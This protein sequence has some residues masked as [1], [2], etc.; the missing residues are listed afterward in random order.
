MC[1]KCGK[2]RKVNRLDMCENCYRA[3]RCVYGFEYWNKK[4]EIISNNPD[5]ISPDLTQFEKMSMAAKIL[6][7]RK[8]EDRGPNC[9]FCGNPFVKG[10]IHRIGGLWGCKNCYHQIRKDTM[11]ESS[12][13]A[14]LEMKTNKLS[15]TF[16]INKIRAGWE[17]LLIFVLDKNLDWLFQGQRVIIVTEKELGINTKSPGRIEP[18]RHYAMIDQ[19]DDVILQVDESNHDASCGNWFHTEY[20]YYSAEHES[21]NKYLYN[22][23]QYQFRINTRKWNININGPNGAQTLTYSHIEFLATCVWTYINEIINSKKL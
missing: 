17:K 19:P 16:L 22:N 11:K 3:Q 18:D 12:F 23:I 10:K 8:I 9:H 4:K 13:F 21:S 7:Q 15:T 14:R 20:G 5:L 1:S 2:E 6:T